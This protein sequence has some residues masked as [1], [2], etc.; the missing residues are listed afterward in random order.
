MPTE[1]NAEDYPLLPL[2]KSSQGKFEFQD[3]SLSFP[4]FVIL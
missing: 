4:A 2:N 3:S 1:D